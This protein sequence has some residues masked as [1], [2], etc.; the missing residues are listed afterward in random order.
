M[1][2]GA[3][4]GKGGNA[5]PDASDLDGGDLPD[6]GVYRP[7]KRGRAPVGVRTVPL[8]DA[9]RGQRAVPVEV[10]YPATEL[11][12]RVDTVKDEHKKAELKRR[13]EDAKV[14]EKEAKD[15]GVPYVAKEFFDGAQDKFYPAP[16]HDPKAQL[17]QAQSAVRDAALD[18][19]RGPFPIVLF[20][21]GEVE[22]R[23]S[24]SQICTHLASH[25]YVVFSA[26]HRGDTFEDML[27]D[28][29]LEG[30]DKDKGGKDE[31]LAKNK[32]L[33][34]L[35]PGTRLSDRVAD[36]AFLQGK[37][38]DGSCG[39]PVDM[40]RTED[41][42]LVGHGIGGTAVIVHGKTAAN[43]RGIIALA[44]TTG[45]APMR[46]AEVEELL[47]AKPEKSVP[48]LYLAAMED[49][50]SPIDPLREQFEKQLAM[51]QD[52]V[53]PPQTK[54]LAMKKSGHFHY[55]TYPAQSNAAALDPKWPAV[56]TVGATGDGTTDPAMLHLNYTSVQDVMKPI[57]EMQ[58]ITDVHAVVITSVC[59]HCDANV[60]LNDAVSE[61]ADAFVL[62][63]LHGKMYNV[64]MEVLP[65]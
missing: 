12:R 44:P 4:S 61:T 31:D 64:E 30:G 38:V 15:K 37:V 56:R 16:E 24:C 36:L 33:R 40:L 28:L 29:E 19:E 53:P 27:H 60:R 47:A 22:H 52:F 45:A 6:D 10:Y 23:R 35:R 59:A 17:Y 34:M 41:I 46:N 25:G 32:D 7:Y 18:R 11:Y 57:A 50:F 1:G 9:A 49:A 39:I 54:L 26:D 55:V 51:A 5:P 21:H 65:Q 3:S 8:L 62:K 13:E 58:P 42:G 2:C 48:T 14:A 63:L 20:S 43:I